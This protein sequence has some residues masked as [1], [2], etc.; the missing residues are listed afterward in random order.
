MEKFFDVDLYINSSSLQWDAKFRDITQ[1][2]EIGEISGRVEGKVVRK[3]NIKIF[4][5]GNSSLNEELRG[6]GYGLIMYEMI[7][8]KIFSVWPKSEFHSS[9]NLN[10]FSKG[11]WDILVDKYLNVKKVGRHYEIK[12]DNMRILK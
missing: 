7:A 9:S 1:E 11:V 4:I 6:K 12:C 3:E 5:V 10:N 2:T 8:K